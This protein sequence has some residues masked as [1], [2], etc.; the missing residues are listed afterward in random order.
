MERIGKVIGKKEKRTAG[1]SVHGW[2][3]LFSSTVER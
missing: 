3:E 2:M 1:K